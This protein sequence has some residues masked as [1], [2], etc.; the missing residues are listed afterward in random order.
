[1]SETDRERRFEIARTI[2]QGA[3]GRRSGFA[4]P[5][6][7]SVATDRQ[8]AAEV[9]EELLAREYLVERPIFPNE[10]YWLAEGDPR[11]TVLV[12][13]ALGQRALAARPELEALSRSSDG[14]IMSEELPIEQASE[15]QRPEI[16]SPPRG[17]LGLVLSAVSRPEGSTLEE[18]Q[19]ITGWKQPSVR[20]ALS[21]GLRKHGYV[22]ELRDTDAGKRYL[23]A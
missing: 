10:A 22:I 7:A 2:L 12:I 14:R 16:M 8:M 11:T 23:V 13:T 21:S 18:L 3:D 15:E 5:L 9:L 4:L 20:A 6:P 1:M 19:L 17:K